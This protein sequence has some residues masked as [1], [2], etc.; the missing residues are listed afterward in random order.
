M[1]TR[2]D[3]PAAIDAL[4]AERPA[5]HGRGPQPVNWQLG[6]DLLR[7]LVDNVPAGGTT[8]ETGCGYSTVAFAAVSGAHTVV[9]PIPEEHER[10]QAWCAANGVPTDHVDFVAAPSQRWLPEAEGAGRLGELDVVLV[11]GDH[12]YPIPGIDWYYTAGALRVGGLMVVD[13]VSIRAC[14]DLR[15]FLE[16]E[17]GRWRAV[18]TVDDATVFRKEV[19]AVVEY[20]PWN[21]QPWN[22]Q[23][24]G[25]V[26]LVQAARNRVRLRSRLRQRRAA[27]R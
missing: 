4:L 25:A 9:S 18:R 13:D 22:R 23:R 20:R 2:T 19:A 17:R 10:V 21:Q 5:F 27:A 15:R 11:D 3:A 26:G 14:G 16:A 7:W 6:N 8:L 12:A 1:R 24:V